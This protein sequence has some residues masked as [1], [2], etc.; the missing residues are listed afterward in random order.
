MKRLSSMLSRLQRVNIRARILA[1]RTMQELIP[2]RM[3]IVPFSWPLRPSVCPCDLDLCHYLKARDVRGKTIFHFGSGGHHTVGRCNHDDGLDN[4]IMAVTASPAEHARYVR[5]VVSAAALGTR[6]KVLFAD[7]YDLGPRLLPRFDL[8]S[9]FHLCEFTPPAKTR[10][11]L[12]D[13]GVLSLF[14]HQAKPD[15]RFLFYTGSFGWERARLL[16]N[17]AEAAGR[18]SFEERFASLFV[19]RVTSS[20]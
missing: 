1:E 11:R 13:E 2:G 5:K 19:Y 16:V 7:I 12:D 18:L 14:M 8:V 20:S 9:L 17:R 4:E 10:R 3:S 6:Y 15:G